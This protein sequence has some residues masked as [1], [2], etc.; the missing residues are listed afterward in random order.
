MSVGTGGWE[1]Q[2]KG[3]VGGAWT[4]SGLGVGATIG[5]ASG[6]V[7]GQE[8]RERVDWAAAARARVVVCSYGQQREQQQ[9]QS[10]AV[11]R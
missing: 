6:Q 10:G 5:E 2:T 4:W 1:S 7:E 9:Q 11:A 3:L 8:T